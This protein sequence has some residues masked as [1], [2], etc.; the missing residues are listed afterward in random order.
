MGHVRMMAAVQPFL[1]G[2]ISK[3]VNLPTDCTVDDIEE[4]YLEAWKLGLKAIAVYRDGCKRTQPLSTSA[5]AEPGRGGADPNGLDGLS[6]AEQAVVLAMREAKGQ[7]VGPPP[8]IRYKLSDERRSLTH[9]FSIAGHDGYITVGL[10]EDGKPGEIFVRMAKEGSVIAG[11]M[12]SFAT[13]VSLSLQH[14]VPL[15]L[16]SEKFKGTRFEP[17]GFTGNQEIPIATSIMDYL[18]RWLALRFLDD[19]VHPAAR[20]SV[21][22]QLDLPRV[23]VLPGAERAEAPATIL[24]EVA[25]QSAGWVRETDAPPCHECGALM[26]RSG[27][28]YKCLNCGSTSGCS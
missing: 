16:L 25:G 6:D 9:K 22:G 7:P 18:F 10:Y 20:V 1:S 5:D 26:V 8:A 3:T 24:V 21:R 13:A 4:A 27:S 11:L 12:D 28:C 14:G 15:R 19:E 23:P 2:A 17:S